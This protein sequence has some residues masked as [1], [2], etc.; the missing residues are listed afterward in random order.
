MPRQPAFTFLPGGLE[1][2]TWDFET[3]DRKARAL[4]AT[5]G[6]AR[7]TGRRAVIALPSGLDYIGAF[8][9]CLYNGTIAI[10]TYPPRNAL[11]LSRV[12]A[13]ARDAGADVLIAPQRILDLVRTEADIAPVL[14]G[15]M[16]L[17]IERVDD[18]AA[19]RFLPG[20]VDSSATAFLQYTSGS[21]SAPKGVMLTHANISANEGMIE[22][23]FGHDRSTRV[24]GWLPLFHD[25]GLIGQ[26]LQPLWLGVP[27]VLL[28]PTTFVRRP[29]DWLRAIS[30]FRATTSGGPDFAYRFCAEEITEDEKADLDLSCWRVAFNGAEPVRADTLDRFAE[31]FAC[32]G[33]RREAFYPCFGMAEATLLVSGGSIAAPP[34]RKAVDATRLREGIA[35]PP[36]ST[37]PARVL[38]GCGRSVPGS[39]L[40]IVDP[41]TRLPVSPGRVGE[42][43]IAGP[44]V[45]A[46]YLGN[47]DASREAFAAYLECPGGPMAGPFLRSGDL[48]FLD[49]DGELYVVGRLKDL[50]IVRGRNHAPH[51]LEAT[52]EQAR[53]EIRP[54]GVAAFSVDH[55]A[56]E[57]VVI[58]AELKRD[59]SADPI[60]IGRAIRQA[61]ARH[62][63][64]EL[65]AVCLVP[66]GA[67]PKTTSGKL[68]RHACRR[69]WQEG[70]YPEEPQPAIRPEAQE[71][72]AKP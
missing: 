30:R 22:A 40:R 36:P 46:G 24:A 47:P 21:T 51:D 60:A 56:G 7:A 70:R 39:D 17:A 57:R 15:A 9:G 52:V 38:V 72:T 62:H 27:S 10:S 12:E 58:V 65:H 61:V 2:T 35:A 20:P 3:L 31:A 5:L 34:V 42:I 54:A 50:I 69:A 25:M 4:A 23:A 53:A 19:A 29:V 6:E 37:G 48:G 63:E 71:A 66:S 28:P 43:W 32:C 68:Q 49:E 11:Q 59:V 64:L 14:N 41:E 67:V 55:E 16:P 44:H 8:L 33:F 13:I 26:V 45:G 18:R 1:A